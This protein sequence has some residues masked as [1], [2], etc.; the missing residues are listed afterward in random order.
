LWSAKSSS[1]EPVGVNYFILDKGLLVGIKLRSFEK[2]HG[3][4]KPERVK[5][6]QKGKPRK[7]ENPK[8]GTGLV[9]PVKRIHVRSQRRSSAV[10]NHVI[11]KK[12]G[13]AWKV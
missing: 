2:R 12:D 11:L 9:E 6:D 3:S 8:K 7:S 10:K 5:A 1:E 13:V 4:M